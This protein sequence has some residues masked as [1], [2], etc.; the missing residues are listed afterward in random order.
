MTE[1]KLSYGFSGARCIHHGYRQRFAGKHIG[2]SYH[3]FLIEIAGYWLFGLRGTEA[4]VVLHSGGADE[5]ETH[6]LLQRHFSQ[7]VLASL[8]GR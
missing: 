2:R 4:L 8:F 3:V 6:L 5:H 7:Q 1:V